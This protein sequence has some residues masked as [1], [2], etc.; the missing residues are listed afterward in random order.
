MPE[1]NPP[2]PALDNPATETQDDV[3]GIGDL[4]RTGPYTPPEG[5]TTGGNPPTIPGYE[6]EGLLGRGG[7]GV[8]YR[9]RHLALKRVVALKMLLAGTHAG[10]QMRDRFWT[11]AEAVARLQHPH[12]VQIYELGEHDGLP[13]F[14]LEYVDGPSLQ[15]RLRENPLPPLETARLLEV[16]CQA[17]EAAHQAGVIHRDLKPGNI[18]LTRDGAPKVADFGLAKAI[19][20]DNGQTQSGQVLGTPSYMAPEQASGQ[21]SAIGPATDVYALGAI[22]YEMLTG[23]APFRG[24]NIADTLDLVRTREPI[25]PAELQPRVPADLNT[26]CLKCLQKEPGKRYASACELGEDLQ[27]YLD[28][29]PI[30]A[31][32]VG[33]LERL[34]RWRRRN[35][36]IAALSVTIA[37]LLVLTTIGAVIEVFRVHG[38]YKDLESTNEKLTKKTREAEDNFDDAKKNAR[39]AKENAEKEKIAKDNAKSQEDHAYTRLDRMQVTNGLRRLELNDFSGA[40]LSYAEALRVNPDNPERVRVNRQRVASYLRLVPPLVASFNTRSENRENLGAP[41]RPFRQIEFSPDGRFVLLLYQSVGQGQPF[42]FTV[43][44]LAG[45]SVFSGEHQANTDLPVPVWGPRGRSLVFSE[46]GKLAI[47]DAAA[48]KVVKPA[49]PDSVGLVPRLRIVGSLVGVGAAGLP[50]LLPLLNQPVLL[51]YGHF[52]DFSRGSTRQAVVFSHDGSQVLYDDG[53]SWSLLNVRGGMLLNRGPT[54]RSHNLNRRAYLSPDGRFVVALQGD[55]QGGWQLVVTDAPTGQERVLPLAQAAVL[56]ALNRPDNLFAFSPDGRLF[57]LACGAEVYLWDMLTGEP[58][59][60]PLEHPERIH[61]LRFSPDGRVLLTGAA[62]IPEEGRLKSVWFWNPLTGR[63]LGEPLRQEPYLAEM[64]SRHTWQNTLLFSPRADFLLLGKAAGKQLWSLGNGKPVEVEIPSLK[65]G[66]VD[67]F[68][69]EHF[70][71]DGRSFLFL[72]Q[73]PDGGRE[74]RLIRLAEPKKVH[75]AWALDKEGPVEFRFSPDGQRIAL[76]V[77]GEARVYDLDGE[78]PVVLRPLAGQLVPGRGFGEPESIRWA[79]DSRHLLLVNAER[80]AFWVWDT[81]RLEP[82]ALDGTITD[83]WLAA[84][85]SEGRVLTSTVDGTLRVHNPLTSEPL[86]QPWKPERG[87]SRAW[88]SK[89]G[90]RVFTISRDALGGGHAPDLGTEVQVWDSLTGKPVFPAFRHRS[91]AAAYTA[92][93]SN[94]LRAATL[95]DGGSLQL[96]DIATLAPSGLPYLEEGGVKDVSFSPW[97]D[98]LRVTRKDGRVRMLRPTST[99]QAFPRGPFE[100]AAGLTA[101]TAPLSLEGPADLIQCSVSSNVRAL[102]LTDERT[103][104]L[105]NGITG[106]P[107]G[108][109]LAPGGAV[110]QTYLDFDPSQRIPRVMLADDKGHVLFAHLEAG[111]WKTHV[112]SLEPGQ[113]RLQ[114]LGQGSDQWVAVSGREVR[115]FDAAGRPLTPVLRHEAVVQEATVLTTYNS[116]NT[117]I[118]LCG[119]NVFIWN[120]KTGKVRHGPLRHDAPVSGLEVVGQKYLVTLSGKEVRLWDADKGVQAGKPLRCDSAVRY[121]WGTHPNNEPNKPQVYA[122]TDTTIQGYDPL[123]DRPVGKS[124]TLERPPSALLRSWASAGVAAGSKLWVQSGLPG[125]DS[126]EPIEHKGRIVHAALVPGGPDVITVT[127]DGTVRK[128]NLYARNQPEQNRTVACGPEATFWHVDSNTSRLLTADKEGNI[129]EWDLWQQKPTGQTWKVAGP[130][131]ETTVASNQVLVRTQSGRLAVFRTNSPEAVN[132][133]IAS[134]VVRTDPVFYQNE[135]ITRVVERVGSEVRL[136]QAEKGARVG[137]TLRHDEP[138]KDVQPLENNTILITRT[139]AGTVRTWDSLTGLPL[140]S[141]L[142]VDEAGRPER[143]VQGPS[144]LKLWVTWK[145]KDVVVWDLLQGKSLFVQSQDEPVVG[146]EFNG[147]TMLAVIAGKNARLWDVKTGK[148]LTPLMEHPAPLRMGFFAW[149]SLYTITTEDELRVWSGGRLAFPPLRLKGLREIYTV[150]QQEFH[151]MTDRVVQRWNVFT[152]QLVASVPLGGKATGWKVDPASG[153]CVVTYEDGRAAALQTQQELGFPPRQS[154]RLTPLRLLH[155]ILQ[156]ESSPDGK[157]LLM[158]GSD[159]TVQMWDAERGQPLASGLQH[160]QETLTEARFLHDGQRVLTTGKTRVLWDARNGE[161]LAVFPDLGQAVYAKPEAD[162]AY[163]VDHGKPAERV[164]LMNGKR[165]PARFPAGWNPL[166]STEPGELLV[167]VQ[168]GK[169]EGTTEAQVWDDAREQCVGSLMRLPFS[170]LE[171][172]LSPDGKRL[173][174]VY[175]GRADQDGSGLGRPDAYEL[176]IWDVATGQPLTPALSVLGLTG[177][178]YCFTPDSACLLIVND[179]E[180][181]LW[182]ASTGDPVSP[183]LRIPV[184]TST[185]RFSADA[186]RLLLAGPQQTLVHTLSTPLK[187]EDLVRFTRAASGRKLDET[188]AF[189]PLPAAEIQQALRELEQA[190]SERGEAREKRRRA[191]H[192]ERIARLLRKGDEL[193]ALSHLTCLLAETDEPAALQLRRAE[194]LIQ[195]GRS[196]AARQELDLAL[197]CERTNPKL[198]HMRAQVRIGAEQWSA[199]AEDLAQAASLPGAGSAVWADQAVLALSRG[200]VEGCRRAGVTL[201]ERF[202]KSADPNE[203]LDVLGICLLVRGAGDPERLTELA[204]GLEDVPDLNQAAPVL[205]GLA[206]YRAGKLEQ[207]AAAMQ[208]GLR[209]PVSFSFAPLPPSSLAQNFLTAL[210]RRLGR[211]VQPAQP[212]PSPLPTVVGGWNILPSPRLVGWRIEPIHGHFTRELA[213][214]EKKP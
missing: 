41:V 11:E 96:W 52:S 150:N 121:F 185:I 48:G 18:L 61:L 142:R 204:Q 68:T 179:K 79:P 128:I 75:R 108:E 56:Q 2:L 166:W 191:W 113:V 194:L 202:G 141:P 92:V 198:W 143:R 200:D 60:P 36:A 171:S 89:D 176:R 214:L 154:L 160:P 6:I 30:L 199:A 14:S 138:V 127:E 70:S 69:Q 197:V 201:L 139:E 32:R 43:A 192:E 20:A 95:Q 187:N 101:A 10:Q 120:G 130:V 53:L 76:A 131:A 151:I 134:K 195:L 38:M 119:T 167:L 27:R 55:G 37:L 158:R 93:A 74:L 126:L 206:Y 47:Y 208:Q 196:N 31:R 177:V 104:Q 110:G 190:S 72:A 42:P 49:F 90:Q 162:L 132:L 71:P 105:V 183:P 107:I 117:V 147:Q 40:L 99:A 64:P 140:S 44:D 156:A 77:P 129:R 57:A 29:R 115:L 184:N 46:K 78:A 146:A 180:A 149:N 15:A 67:P 123:G 62:S 209:R 170:L 114:R 19:D 65:T 163:W 86:S 207:A 5:G 45:D 144:S 211:P 175:P 174:L 164:D 16:L 102:T 51:P 83:V 12:I 125:D 135:Q 98:L 17:V 9:A 168:A 111:K 152:G 66:F 153:S 178:R 213:E 118:T 24:A 81:E 212:F 1:P 106:E 58:A 124:V 97:G 35:P 189:L 155:R 25:S 181:R 59:A 3:P 23:R 7:M 82:S 165:R 33:R 145:G 73:I 161:R 109:P 137:A 54:A 8:V 4:Q 210:N 88:L 173:A 34:A 136:W 84:D 50:P 28:G 80:K 87:V 159:Q 203:R 94:G 157:V 122:V 91:A 133:P 182:D 186:G 13:Y 205:L 193:A 22:L 100:T 63:C 112:E 85:G 103:A 26:I 172:R 188:G 21:L 39:E 169:K 116:E 148:P